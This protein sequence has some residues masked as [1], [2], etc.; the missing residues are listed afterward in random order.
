MRFANILLLASTAHA[1][2][3]VSV[4]IDARGNV[5]YSDLH[6][7]LRVA[8]DGTKSVVVP[9]VHTHELYLDAQGNLFGEHL[10]YEG[11]RTDKWGHYVWTRDAAGRV[12]RVIPRTEGFLTNYSFVRDA[13]GNM[14]WA[15]RDK[16]EIRKRAPNGAITRVAGELKEMRWMHATP[17]GTLYVID[18]SD[19]VRVKG[20]RATRL[21]RNVVKTSL[22]APFIGLNHAVMG[23]WT[24]RAENVYYA[25]YAHSEVKRVTQAGQV[26]TVVKSKGTW[27]PTGGAFAANGDLWV[28]ETSVTNQVRVR[29]VPARALGAGV[30]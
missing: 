25:D 21:A 16:G 17:A 9:G 23:V 26:S 7:V 22:L 12:S 20:G 24:D 13:A 10:W 14:Y 28:L 29:R 5:Y 19:L 15:Q 2:P 11:E 8:P 3:S 1:H 27:S 4:V 6:L 30:H 18:G